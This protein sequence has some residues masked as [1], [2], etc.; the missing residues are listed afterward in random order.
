[1]ADL[2]GTKGFRGT[3]L[4]FKHASIREEHREQSQADLDQCGAGSGGQ[5]GLAFLPLAK[6]EILEECHS[7]TLESMIQQN[8]LLA[9][10][11]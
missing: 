9:L 6:V 11:S 5:D 4:S 10:M 8:L 2:Q 7:Q 3:L 1:M